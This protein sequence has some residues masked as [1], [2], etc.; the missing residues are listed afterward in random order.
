MKILAIDVGRTS[1]FAFLDGEYLETGELKL[2]SLDQYFKFVKDLILKYKPDAV[3][4]AR[5]TRFARVIAFQSKLLAIV[6][7]T[8]ER[9]ELPIFELIDSECKL[10]VLGKGVIPK[11]HIIDY[12]SKKYNISA[13]SEHES[14]AVMFAEFVQIKATPNE[15]N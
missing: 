6:E 13:L 1:G 3:C 12:V 15:E 11:E 2:Q 14:D 9:A 8:T 10:A 4:S 7:L 5:P